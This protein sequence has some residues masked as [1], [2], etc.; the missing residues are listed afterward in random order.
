MSDTAD[1]LIH[2]A[3]PNVDLVLR[4]YQQASP[5]GEGLFDANYCENVRRN[6][7]PGQSPDGRKWDEWS[8]DGEPASPWNGASDT[9]VP[10][11]VYLVDADKKVFD[12]STQDAAQELT[13]NCLASEPKAVELY[14]Q[15]KNMLE[16]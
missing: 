11:T 8:P 4:E 13:L 2:S 12:L 3:E 9:R 16:L 1:Q 15:L 10:G 7:W 6:L 14:Q 5:L